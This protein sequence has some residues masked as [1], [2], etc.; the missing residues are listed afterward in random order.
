MVCF[1]AEADNENIERVSREISHVFFD[2][3]EMIGL[4]SS[5]MMVLRVEIVLDSLVQLGL[6]RNRLAADD[7][8][9]KGNGLT[10]ELSLQTVG[11]DGVQLMVKDSGGKAACVS[12]R[13]INQY[14]DLITFDLTNGG[15]LMRALFK[16]RTC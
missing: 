12:K 13:G 7:K 2:Q 1:G 4:L 5:P 14:V 9:L 16:W 8:T 10:I 11:G 6:A 15:L 3:L